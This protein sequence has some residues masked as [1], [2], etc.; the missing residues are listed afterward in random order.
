MR[1]GSIRIKNALTK[2]KENSGETPESHD[3]GVWPGP[4]RVSEV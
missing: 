2:S 1:S 3:L 4:H